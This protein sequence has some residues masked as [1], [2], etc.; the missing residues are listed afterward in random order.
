MRDRAA[1]KK[2]YLEREKENVLFHLKMDITM[3]RQMT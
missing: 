3:C 1:N 2:G